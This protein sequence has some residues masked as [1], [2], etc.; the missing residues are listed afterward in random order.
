MF[1]MSNISHPV[2]L[3][4][5]TSLR[6]AV[7]EAADAMLKGISVYVAQDCTGMENFDLKSF[8]EQQKGKYD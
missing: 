4:S 8:T 5:Y 1:S 7:D 3:S 2:T 6:K